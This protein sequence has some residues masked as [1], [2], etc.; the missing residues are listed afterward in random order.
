MLKESKE[1][2]ELQ[3]QIE[4]EKTKEVYFLFIPNNLKKP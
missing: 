1:Q 3:K 2:K 4:I